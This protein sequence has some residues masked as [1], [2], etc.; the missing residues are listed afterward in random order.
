MKNILMEHLFPF[1]SGQHGYYK[2][3]NDVI[4]CLFICKKT[5]GKSIVVEISETLTDKEKPINSLITNEVDFIMC[6]EKY[7]EMYKNDYKNMERL[8]TILRTALISNDCSPFIKLSS[9]N[10]M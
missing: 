9:Y 4:P 5:N 8:L 10:E 7:E 1:P 6:N 3:E 2:I